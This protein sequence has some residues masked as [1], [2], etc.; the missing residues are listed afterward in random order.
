MPIPAL[1]SGVSLVGGVVRAFPI[2]QHRIFEHSYVAGCICSYKQPDPSGLV[3]PKR[4][5]APT[6]WVGPG[7]G[8]CSCHKVLTP[9]TSLQFEPFCDTLAGVSKNSRA[10]YMENESPSG[11]AWKMGSACQNSTGFDD[12]KQFGNA[13]SQCEP[14]IAS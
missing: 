3:A 9:S 5:S 12:H 1:H 8:A 11:V 2:A 7:W 14:L 10:G 4:Q 6:I 13:P